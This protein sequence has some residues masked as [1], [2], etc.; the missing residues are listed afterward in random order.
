LDGGKLETRRRKKAV[1]DGQWQHYR[2]T[3]DQGE[4]ISLSVTEAKMNDGRLDLRVSAT[5]RLHGFANVMQWNRGIRTY[6]VSADCDA[7]VR[8]DL[9]CQVALQIGGGI[10]APN[11]SIDPKVTRTHVELVDFRLT[12][13]GGVDGWL[14]KQIGRAVEDTLRDRL[15]RRDEKLADSLNRSIAKHRDELRVS[16]DDFIKLQWTKAAAAIERQGAK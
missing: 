4:P 5:A 10:L 2:V 14:A 12:R 11:L 6:S 16:A 3:R 8:L 9:D 1:N 7:T 13:V 15:S